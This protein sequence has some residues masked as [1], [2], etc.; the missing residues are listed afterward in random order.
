MCCLLV[1]VF[2]CVSVCTGGAFSGGS[3]ALVAVHALFVYL[4]SSCL[5]ARPACLPACVATRGYAHARFAYVCV[6]L[7]VCVRACLGL[8]QCLHLCF[9]LCVCVCEDLGARAI[10]CLFVCLFV[11]LGLCVCWHAGL[12][13]G[14]RAWLYTL[15]FS[16]R[17]PRHVIL[18]TGSGSL[19]KCAA[20]IFTYAPCGTLQ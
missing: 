10:V 4:S 3:S 13:Q 9:F 20:E 5:P 17:S 11:C 14:V 19:W 16:P 6:L 1:P 8:C 7:C 15:R 12:C 18:R 2:A